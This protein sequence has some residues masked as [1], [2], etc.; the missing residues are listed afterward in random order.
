MALVFLSTHV[1]K[2]EDTVFYLNKGEC[3]TGIDALVF[4]TF[5]EVDPPT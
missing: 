4:H 1:R 2:P 5:C 3:F